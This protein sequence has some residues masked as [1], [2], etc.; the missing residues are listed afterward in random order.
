[1]LLN[2]SLRLPY[3]INTINST[4][5]KGSLAPREA[6]ALLAPRHAL[7]AAGEHGRCHRKSPQEG[8]PRVV[9][10]I[11]CPKATQAG[12]LAESPLSPSL[13]EVNS[14]GHTTA[15]P[16]A[17]SRYSRVRRPYLLRVKHKRSCVRT[18]CPRLRVFL[19]IVSCF[20]C[21]ARIASA[22]CVCSTRAHPDT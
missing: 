5:T 19:F 15:A 16:G 11:A 18:Y 1:M 10:A 2:Y 13:L 12:A 14:G 20:A 22:R 3:P 21:E 4:E 17:I 9:R 6:R 8:T 7:G